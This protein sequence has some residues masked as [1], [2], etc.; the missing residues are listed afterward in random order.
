MASYAK[1]KCT[2]ELTPFLFLFPGE[3]S[4]RMVGQHAPACRLCPVLFCFEFGE[5]HG[6]KQFFHHFLLSPAQGKIAAEVPAIFSFVSGICVSLAVV[7]L[8][9]P[10]FPQAFFFYL[11][12]LSYTLLLLVL[13]LLLLVFLILFL[14]FPSKLLSQLIISASL[15]LSHGTSVWEENSAAAC[16]FISNCFYTTTT[17]MDI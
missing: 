13:L 14:F 3:Q 16:S 9:W 12:T 5:E 7:A 2:V 15:S 1:Q 6:C 17:I 11:I 8:G 4:D 10:G